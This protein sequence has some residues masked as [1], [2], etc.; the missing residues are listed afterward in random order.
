MN[1]PACSAAL[2]A[3]AT[4]CPTCGATVPPPP[5][6]PGPPPADP[7]RSAANW[8]IATA[9]LAPCCA[10]VGFVSGFFAIR[11][12]Q[13]ARGAKR[14]VPNRAGIAI[15]LSVLS[16]A[17]W[18]WFWVSFTLHQREMRQKQEAVQQ[19]LAG[20]RETA[21]L[22]PGVACDLVEE[23]LRAGLYEGWRADTVACQGK[24]EA[25][26][27]RAVLKGV[28]M[29][30]GSGRTRLNACL[31][32]EQ[33]WFVYRVTLRD[34]CPDL[35]PL[36]GA[37]PEAREDAA[38][39]QLAAQGDHDD[40]AEFL[41]RLVRVRETI[42]T[43]EPRER[44][45]PTID[46]ASLGN[47]WL[48]DS[49]RVRTVDM[50][51]LDLSATTRTGSAWEFLTSDEVRTALESK[52][53]KRERAAAVQRIALDG[54]PYIVVYRSDARQWPYL[55]EDLS[56]D[57]PTVWGGRWSGWMVVADLRDGQAVCQTELSVKMS[58]H[59]EGGSAQKRL[60][61]TLGAFGDE[62]RDQATQR[63]RAMSERQLRLGYKLLE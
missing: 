26:P 8:A 42:S 9:L 24:L 37:T 12:I 47:S 25:G 44:T 30:L 48:P 14:P 63:M 51:L 22:E 58:A 4:W 55:Q 39:S 13:R 29:R 28:E 34:S 35:P 23:Q 27:D 10:P 17:V 49:L 11:A 46:I 21:T 31:A 54:G 36:A 60:A 19:R 6:P 57:Q 61:K 7:V 50:E 62:F 38:R 5:P 52:N 59:R 15:G 18:I 1:C 3:G 43:A 33:R 2:E 32:R 20:K 45:C 40:V 53:S 56:D 16:A 41:A